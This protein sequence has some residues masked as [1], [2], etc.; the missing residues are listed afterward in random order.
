MSRIFREKR[1]KL[2]NLANLVTLTSAK[3]KREKPSKNSQNTQTSQKDF[4]L[5]T[6]SKSVD[7]KTTIQ[8]LEYKYHERFIDSLE[9]AFKNI[10]EQLN[11]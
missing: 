5:V 7:Y 2:S 8:V 11:D 9:N 10:F 1:L 3:K 4:I 6:H